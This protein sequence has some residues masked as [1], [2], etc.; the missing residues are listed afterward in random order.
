[1]SFRE[2]LVVKEGVLNQSPE[3][4]KARKLANANAAAVYDLLSL[5][6]ARWS[7]FQL[8]NEVCHLIE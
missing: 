6:A 4:E 7:Q 2:S 1:V 5:A 8:V 3:F